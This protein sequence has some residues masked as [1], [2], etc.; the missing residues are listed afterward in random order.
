MTLEKHQNMRANVDRLWF[1]GEANSAQF[2]GY[3]QGAY[4]EGQ[5][6]GDRI[7]RIIGGKDTEAALQMKRYEV[8]EGTTTPDE[9]NESNGWSVPSE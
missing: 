8:L 5:E 4:F 3:L 2:F 9:Y 1:A 7:A 6:I